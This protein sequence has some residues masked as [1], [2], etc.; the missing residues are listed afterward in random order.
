M[1]S[2]QL[3]R[4]INWK[5]ELFDWEKIIIFPQSRA[6]V[7]HEN[8]PANPA[9]IHSALLELHFKILGLNNFKS[10]ASSDVLISLERKVCVHKVTL[11]KLQ[12]LLNLR[13]SNVDSP[14]NFFNG[15]PPKLLM[16]VS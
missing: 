3:R 5:V 11:L 12:K 7:R 15:K 9:A 14:C 8:S 6:D 10:P 13:F 4:A 2:K 16:E 1:R